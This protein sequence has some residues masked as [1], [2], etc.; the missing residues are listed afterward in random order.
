MKLSQ[1]QKDAIR[2][3]VIRRVDVF[4]D[5]HDTDAERPNV[6]RTK[7]AQQRDL[8]AVNCCCLCHC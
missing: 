5:E 7:H 4:T 6:S 3:S 2:I 8:L 1:Q